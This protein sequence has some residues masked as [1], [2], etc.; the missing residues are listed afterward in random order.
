MLAVIKSRLSSYSRL[1]RIDRPIGTL[2]LLWPTLTALW[3]A[4]EGNPTPYVVFV[5]VVGVALMRAVGCIIND[6]A[7][8]KLDAHVERTKGRPLAT[9]EIS[10]NEALYLF[11]VMG[12]ICFGLVLTLNPMTVY[13]SF[14]G[15][16]LTMLYPFMKRVTNMPQM[17]LGVVWSWSI[18]MAYAAQVGEVNATTWWLFLANWCLTV[19]Y[20][21]MY[22]MVDRDDDLKVGIKST[23]ILFGRYDRHWIG[24]FQLATV[25]ALVQVGR[26][27]GL[28]S[29]Y[30]LGLLAVIGTFVYQQALIFKRDKARCFQAFLNNNYSGL[31]LFGSVIAAYALG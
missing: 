15:I 5:F 26:L 23:A 3:I 29:W 18:P 16:L 27:E 17:V 6:F 4:G 2:L 20:D 12:L 21:S 28:S 25:V 10:E 19:A 1:T 7:D 24:M 8:R 13:F 30:W 31:L 9:G 14:G 11:V 22:A